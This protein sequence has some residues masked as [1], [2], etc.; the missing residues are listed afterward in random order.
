MNYVEKHEYVPLMG[1]TAPHNDFVGRPNAHYGEVI[2]PEIL[3][4]KDTWEL[5][6]WADSLQK[7]IVSYTLKNS[8]WHLSL[9]EKLSKKRDQLLAEVALRRKEQSK[10]LLEL[11]LLMNPPSPP[12]SSP[13]RISSMNYK[14]GAYTLQR[15]LTEYRTVGTSAETAPSTPDATSTTP[16]SP[17][18]EE[19]WCF[20]LQGV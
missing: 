4:Q 1:V 6:R 3:H 18:Q 14:G 8:E 11:P 16:D 17:P 20:N 2:A 12:P 15:M 9:C 5:E 7:L 19:N 13:T 10:A